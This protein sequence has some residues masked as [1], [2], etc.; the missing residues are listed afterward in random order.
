MAAL[1]VDVSRDDDVAVMAMRF[2][3]APAL[4]YHRRFPARGDELG[5]LRASMRR[6]L[7]ARKIGQ[8]LQHTLLLAVGEACANSIEH[9]YRNTEPGDVQV[10]MRH[11]ENRGF[12]VEVRD[13]G[14]FKHSAAPGDRGRGTEIM[15][16]LTTDFS[17]ESGSAGTVVRFRVL[18]G[19]VFEP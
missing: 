4:P 19:E 15:R 3:S 5:R 16:R 2:E 13:S 12:D 17:R 1:G 10:D 11:S 7:D 14:S 8:P 18:T 9:A 6:W